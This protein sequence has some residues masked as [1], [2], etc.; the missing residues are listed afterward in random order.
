[1]TQIP[2]PLL[3]GA[4]RRLLILAELASAAFYAF[5]SGDAKLPSDLHTVAAEVRNRLEGVSI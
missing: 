2:D 5:D 4:V 3:E 1:M